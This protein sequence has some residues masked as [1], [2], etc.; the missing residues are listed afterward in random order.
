MIN[1]SSF[2]DHDLDQDPIVILPCNHFYSIST[3]DN[4]FSMDLAYEKQDD[5]YI[6]TKTL[7]AGQI[8]P[9]PRGCIDC[10]AVIHS[11]FRYGRVINFAELQSLERKHSMRITGILDKYSQ[12]LAGTT[13]EQLESVIAR[14]KKSPM[15]CVFEACEASD[16]VEVSAPPAH[17]LIRAMKMLSEKHIQS[18]NTLKDNH[19][20]KACEVLRQC[21]DLCDSSQSHSSACE[22]RLTLSTFLLTFNSLALNDEI[23]RE[24]HEM[25]DWIINHPT[26]FRDMKR[27]AVELKNQDHVADIRSVIKAMHVHDGYD[28][29]GSWSDHWYQ[30]E[31][32]HLYFIGNCG[33]AMQ[34]SRCV[35]CRVAIGG[36]DHQLLQSNRGARERIE[37]LL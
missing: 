26:D 29:G 12:A 10:R 25:L 23:K 35:E 31:N 34:E 28:Y 15:H 32:G 27:K 20:E 18:T 37:G 4:H 21:I 3:M 16:Q 19:Y 30:C 11:V 9:K 17:L 13:C 14:I 36:T 22:V 5:H 6:A 24:A 7:Y 33:Q 2:K 8:D 1:L